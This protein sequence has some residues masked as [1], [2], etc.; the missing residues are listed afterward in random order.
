MPTP[1]MAV[2]LAASESLTMIIEDGL[3][4]AI[5]SGDLPVSTA[6]LREDS[7]RGR[8]F[9]SP[10]VSTTHDTAQ[11]HRRTRSTAFD[12]SFWSSGVRYGCEALAR[13]KTQSVLSPQ[14][15][16]EPA[17]PNRCGWV[18]SNIWDCPGASMALRRYNVA[19][20]DQQCT[21]Q[22]ANSGGFKEGCRTGHQKIR[23]ASKKLAG[24]T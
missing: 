12:V 11:Q 5:H 17:I 16:L 7:R 10:L 18:S 20:G 4:V 24:S 23:P 22:G 8:L 21:H 6:V 14:E 19:A 15:C 2:E 3:D 9:S 1:D 13:A